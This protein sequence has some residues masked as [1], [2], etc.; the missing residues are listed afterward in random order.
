MYF[1][2]L[3]GGKKRIEA[4]EIVSVSLGWTKI[5]KVDVLELGLI[6]GS[7]MKLYSPQTE[8]NTPR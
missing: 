3:D 6:S 8:E 4:S 7:E 2:H 5:I 1:R